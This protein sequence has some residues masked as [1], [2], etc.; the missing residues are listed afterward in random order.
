MLENF[1]G[2]FRKRRRFN[3]PRLSTQPNVNYD[4]DDNNE[5]EN[6]EQYSPSSEETGPYISNLQID[7]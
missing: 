7:R 2:I 1:L 3:E 5:D 4:I 6:D